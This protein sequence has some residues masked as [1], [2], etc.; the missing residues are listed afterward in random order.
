AASNWAEVRQLLAAVERALRDGT[1]TPKGIEL[2]PRRR[3]AGLLAFL[4]PGQGSQYVDMFRETSVYIEELR[5]A[6]EQAD[7]ML[8]ETLGRPLSGLWFPPAAFSSDAERLRSMS[9]L[10]TRFAQP[11]LAA[12]AVGL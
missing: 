3:A 1:S 4:Y 10:D 7:V 2:R 11:A 9:L 8:Y 5:S 6:I 12:A